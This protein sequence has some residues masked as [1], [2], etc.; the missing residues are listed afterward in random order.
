MNFDLSLADSDDGSLAH[1]PQLLPSLPA[2]LPALNTLQGL[3]ALHTHWASNKPLIPGQVMGTNMSANDFGV[4]TR[5]LSA[6]RNAVLTW[7]ALNTLN[8]HLGKPD[9]EQARADTQAYL[10]RAAFS[11]PPGLDL[12]GSYAANQDWIKPTLETLAR[13][14]PALGL[15]PPPNG[16]A[17]FVR[18]W[19]QFAVLDCLWTFT[20]GRET[21]PDLVRGLL[22]PANPL[23]HRWMRSA[24]IPTAQASVAIW[25][26]A[27]PELCELLAY[28]RPI[29][30][31]AAHGY[32]AARFVVKSLG[33]IGLSKRIYRY[34]TG[35]QVGHLYLAT[36]LDQ[37]GPAQTLS[38]HSRSPTASTPAGPLL[39]GMAMPG[40]ADS[41]ATA[42]SARATQHA[43]DQLLRQHTQPAASGAAGGAARRFAPPAGAPV[44]GLPG[45]FDTDGRTLSGAE[46]QLEAWA[47][48]DDEAIGSIRLD[49]QVLNPAVGLSLVR[50]HATVL[51]DGRHALRLDLVDDAADPL[52]VHLVPVMSTWPWRQTDAEVRET[53]GRLRRNFVSACWSLVLEP[54]YAR[55]ANI[56]LAIALRA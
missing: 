4:V 6:R 25:L 32:W 40:S 28:Q 45:R 37:L 33:G 20:A 51:F 14:S 55:V 46:L 34:G 8:R 1:L 44:P 30:R 22:G 43:V 27:H 48:D 52:R 49:P 12:D 21:W 19:N 24:A 42:A 9:F 56:G 47:S 13:A 23:N 31:G 41:D 26:H 5:E 15:P 3:E 18:W 36:L 17:G 39:E 50:L 2:E 53:L 54:D 10:R 16:E 38:L 29:E 35:L 7:A 11:V